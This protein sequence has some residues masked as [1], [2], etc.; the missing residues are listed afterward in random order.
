MG[1]APRSLLCP[2]AAALQLCPGARSAEPQAGR[3]RDH[4]CHQR[5]FQAQGTGS[6]CP[7]PGAAWGSRPEVE[8]GRLSVVKEQYLEPEEVKVQCDCSYHMV[9]PAHIAC[10]ENGTWSPEPPTCAWVSAPPG[11]RPA[12]KR[13]L[14]RT[15]A[16]VPLRPCRLRATPSRTSLRSGPSRS[17]L[18]I[19]M[20]CDEVVAAGSCCSASQTRRTCGWPWRCKLS[21]EIE[22]LDKV[23][24][25]AASAARP[26]QPG[27]P[28]PGLSLS[29]PS[30]GPLL[31]FSLFPAGPPR[32]LQVRGPH[33]AAA[34]AHGPG[35]F[36]RHRVPDARRPVRAAAPA[37]CGPCAARLLRLPPRPAAF[38]CAQ[39]SQLL[40]PTP[41][42]Q[43]LSRPL[44]TP[45][46]A[47]AAVSLQGPD[48]RDAQP[49]R[50]PRPPVA[51]SA[52]GQAVSGN[53]GPD[54]TQQRG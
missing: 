9:G 37:P 3:P 47:R 29:S 43:Q 26:C 12:W 16:R 25:W 46:A 7:S 24:D 22:Q 30:S 11:A 15:D 40:L 33:A 54:Q 51:E 52:A 13:R 2:G 5:S 27:R 45:R 21:L 14:P 34:T 32:D 28:S 44:S 41:P 17:V 20:G 1:A 36:P 6:L 42:P 53:N 4:G 31:P 8:H 38:P 50:S 35:G 10:S 49:W 39:A 48:A 19:A 18:E 23:V